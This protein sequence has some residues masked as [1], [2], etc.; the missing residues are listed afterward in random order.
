M[1]APK[2]VAP[3]KTPAK[4]TP[5]KKAEP[6]PAT[7]AAKPK[8]T[9]SVAKKAV[10]PSAEPI[11]TVETAVAEAIKT[12]EPETIVHSSEAEKK[13]SSVTLEETPA[14]VQEPV[15]E[16]IKAVIEAVEVPVPTT[17]VVTNWD[18]VNLEEPPRIGRTGQMNCDCIEYL[19]LLL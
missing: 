12:D 19:T 15:V 11:A 10:Q 7:P 2:E 5:A 9:K 1:A 14:I 16:Q 4:K 13:D 3:K 18:G 6:K 17:D 8:S